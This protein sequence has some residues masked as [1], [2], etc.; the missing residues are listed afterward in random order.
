[1]ICL[2]INQ[3]EW[4]H[5]IVSYIKDLILNPAFT[6]LTPIDPHGMPVHMPQL[7]ELDP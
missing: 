6:E 3:C 7:Q 5:D 1:M 2:L 4:Y